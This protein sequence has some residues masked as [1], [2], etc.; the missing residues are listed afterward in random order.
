MGEKGQVMHSK[1][2]YKSSNP[3]VFL[4]QTPVFT[5]KELVRWLQGD[6]ARVS[7]VAA[8]N[9]IKNRRRAGQ[10]GVVKEGV[11]FQV[12]PGASAE[13]TPVDQFLV[14]SKLAP[15]AV[16]AFHTALEVLGYGHSLFG[17]HY[18]F[19]GI[20]R[21]PVRFRTGVYRCLK[22]PSTVLKAR[23]QDFGLEKVERLGQKVSVTGR[24]RTLVE[25]LEHPEYFGGFEE[26]YR[27]LEK[28]P[29]LQFDILAGYLELRRKK[30]LFA[31]VGFFLEQHRK[32]FHVEESLLLA[33]ERSKP[34]TPDYWARSRRDNAFVKRWNLIVPR[35]A[36]HRS[37][38]E[39]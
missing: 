25:S 36:L 21:R 37:W 4:E 1:G 12:R 5:L 19:S 2:S 7:R 38:E 15:D 35:S 34:L 3:N 20:Q 33:L 13:T 31:L 23:A 10:L 24:E 32:E 6:T 17:T 29:Y 18:Y 11:Y 9:L 39:F 28:I 14:A 27:S 16:L 30:K 26:M 8:Y 22:F